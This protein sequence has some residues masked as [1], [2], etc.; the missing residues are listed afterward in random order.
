MDMDLSLKCFP[1]ANICILNA[2]V[3]AE[4]NIFDTF[5]FLNCLISLFYSAEHGISVFKEKPWS[6]RQQSEHDMDN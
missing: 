6:M 4:V 3:A 5:M 1:H 2:Q